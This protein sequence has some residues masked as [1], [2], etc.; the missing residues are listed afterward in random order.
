M[1]GIFIWKQKNLENAMLS[2]YKLFLTNNKFMSYYV[3]A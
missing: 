1:Q 3:K 2:S